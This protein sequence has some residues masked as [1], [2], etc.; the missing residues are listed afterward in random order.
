MAK[1]ISTDDKTQSLIEEVQKQKAEISTAENPNYHSK[2]NMT[3]PWVEG[4]AD[5][6][7]LRVENDIKILVKIAGTLIQQEAFY[8]NAIDLLGTDCPK[9]S[10]A[11]YSVED[12]ID[13]IKVRIT[14]IQLKS[15]K[16]KLENLEKRLTAIL[17]PELKTIL[18]LEAI[19]KELS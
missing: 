7:N 15:K 13:D 12:W 18:E 19:A 1:K 14:K 3:F 17:S 9:F 4:R 5:V 2:T 16:Q 6:V 10:W 8:N 11:G